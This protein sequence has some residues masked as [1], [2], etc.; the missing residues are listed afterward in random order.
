[1]RA[2]RQIEDH[3]PHGVVVLPF[4]D[5]ETAARPGDWKWTDDGKSRF[6]LNEQRV[7]EPYVEPTIDEYEVQLQNMQRVRALGEALGRCEFALK[8]EHG[9]VLI[10]IEAEG[11]AETE[12]SISLRQ[13]GTKP[14]VRLSIISSEDAR[15]ILACVRDVL[16]TRLD[17]TKERLGVR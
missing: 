5:V 1:M 16:K 2:L 7:W 3:G 11:V 12:R 6:V 15:V 8:P 9:V 4:R 14:D 17:E 13:A 10:H